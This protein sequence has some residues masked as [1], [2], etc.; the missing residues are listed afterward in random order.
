[1]SFEFG[2]MEGKM[3]ARWRR[4][5]FVFLIA[6]AAAAVI[7]V[8]GWGNSGVPPAVQILPQ[9][10]PFLTFAVVGDSR[11]GDAIYQKIIE[12]VNESGAQFLVHLGDMVAHGYPEEWVAFRKIQTALKIPFYAVPGNHDVYAGR[13]IYA[14]QI[15]EVA[16]A[17]EATSFSAAR[18]YYSL[19]VAGVHFVVL[20]NARG[21][22][23]QEHREWL[24][25]DLAG[26]AQKRIF[27]FM[28]QAPRAKVSEHTMAGD[29]NQA[30]A[31]AELLSLAR[32]S[33]V[34]A[35]FAGHIHGFHEEDLDGV[36]LIVSGGGG[37][38]IYLP[39]FLGG[40]YHWLLVKVYKDDFTVE[41]R[42]VE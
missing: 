31:A 6:V 35:L 12:Q 32:R 24:S 42:K 28:H 17:A 36:R 41:V 15:S 26:N 21:R 40:F 7:L 5:L 38:P 33:R 2:K 3:T 39:E 10:K 25:S 30:T 11:D 22:I 8:L 27:L 18:L 16:S 23:S 4:N 14:R 20:D 9:E 29:A 37:S 1:M 34:S 13:G 19:D